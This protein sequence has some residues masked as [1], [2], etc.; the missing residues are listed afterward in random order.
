MIVF[1][2][3]DPRF[4]FLW[5][6][7]S[8]P[9]GRWHDAGEGPAHYFADTPLG[10]WAELLRHEEIRDVEDL[11]GVR[12]ALWAV[13]VPA[14]PDARPELGDEVLTGGVETYPRC[15]REASRLRL[16]GEPGLRAPSAALR[17]GGATSWVVD[18]G[19]RA[20]PTR[21]GEV[22]VVFDR[23]PGLGGWPV[24]LDGKPPEDVLER[25]RHL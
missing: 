20:G 22:F 1:R 13:D 14:P 6:S 21:D 23:R 18:G 8:Q 19:L 25:V 10:A 11:A 15:R 3:A 12:R 24:V 16:E 17:P 4:P 7:A 2:H 5:E 9:P